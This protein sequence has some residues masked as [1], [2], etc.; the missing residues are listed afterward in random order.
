MPLFIVSYRVMVLSLIA[1]IAFVFTACL[2]QTASHHHRMIVTERNTIMEQQQT[3][4]QATQDG[5]MGETD[6]QSQLDEL[7][8]RLT[9]AS[10]SLA[11]LEVFEQ[12]TLLATTRDAV[13]TIDA[14]AQTEYAEIAS[15][16][17]QERAEVTREDTVRYNELITVIV[18]TVQTTNETVIA[19]EQAFATEYNL[20]VE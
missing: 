20:I 1:M 16:F 19:A 15:L 6:I 3:L 8:R 18:D 2:P 17:A 5:T 12:T 13:T 10:Q 14:L 9:L 7:D 4:L 11:E